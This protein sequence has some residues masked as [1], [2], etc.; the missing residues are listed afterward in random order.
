MRT[1]PSCRAGRLALA[2]VGL[3]IAVACSGNT[4]SPTPQPTPVPPPVP[5]VTPSSTLLLWP[6]GGTE[7]RDWVINN[8]VD[9]DATSGTL[10]Y[11]GGRGSGAKTYDG[12]SGID[13]DVPNFRWM[14]GGVSTVLA[15]A[16]GV[17]TSVHDNEP[18]RNTSCAR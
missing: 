11:T 5:P 2:I 6:L 18:D 15:A 8:Y 3:S 7:G 16:G 9:L 14:D 1:K 4:T 10:D 13:I 17:V 12:H